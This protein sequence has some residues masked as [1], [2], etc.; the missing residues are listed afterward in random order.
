MQCAI[1]IYFICQTTNNIEK[2]NELNWTEL[3]LRV[4]LKRTN[5]FH[6]TE[7]MDKA[8]C[9]AFFG[10]ASFLYS[11]RES[12]KRTLFVK[13]NT[14]LYCI[15]QYPYLNLWFA[16]VKCLNIVPPHYLT[17]KHVN[18]PIHIPL[19]KN[20]KT[21]TCAINNNCWFWTKLKHSMWGSLPLM[22]HHL[23][24]LLKMK[25]FVWNSADKD[26]IFNF[27]KF[28]LV[29]LSIIIFRFIFSNSIINL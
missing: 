10:Q 11:R 12:N 5:F 6:H 14:F 29:F 18:C 19:Q 28:R 23:K 7:T 4:W 8:N 16:D 13:C 22:G 26:N 17:F 1:Q 27:I 24:N 20:R 2:Q 3:N 15:A 25:S 21:N 9:L